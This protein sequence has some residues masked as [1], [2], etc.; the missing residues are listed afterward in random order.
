MDDGSFPRPVLR[1]RLYE[2]VAEQITGWI[3][4]NDLRAGD[5]LPPEREL[6][7][8]LG[9]SRA[10]L[11]QALVALEVIGVVVVRHGDGTVLTERARTGPVIEAIR[12]HADR[13]PEIIEARDALESK[14]AALAAARRTDA[15]LAAIRA[16]LEEMEREIEAGERGVDADGQFHA[17]V[18]AAARSDLLA[19]MMAALEGLIKESRIESLSQPGRPRDSL[20]GHRRIADAIA[21]GDPEA[22]AQAMHDHVMLVSDVALLREQS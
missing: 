18:T 8:R 17:A 22:A 15:D 16:A 5:R 19:Q 12:A 11:S 10:T 21:A 7:V 3:A 13:L 1:T 2:Q 6:A 14:L 20:A 9:V 4:E